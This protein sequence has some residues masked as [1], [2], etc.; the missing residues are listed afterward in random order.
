MTKSV[1]M[2]ELKRMKETTEISVNGEMKN[3]AL[4]MPRQFM[5]GISENIGF[6]NEQLQ[7]WFNVCVAR[8][9]TDEELPKV[10]DFYLKRAAVWRA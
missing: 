7:R 9:V 1:F 6:R 2:N 3:C 10:V 8:N 4:S 5:G